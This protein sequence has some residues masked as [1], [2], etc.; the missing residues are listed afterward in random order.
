MSGS[1]STADHRA[2]DAASSM[3]AVA[4]R[5]TAR[6][7]RA[8][9]VP[10]LTERFYRVDVKRSRERGGTGLGLAIVKHIVN[11]HQGRLHDRKPAGRRQHVHRLS[12][13]R[14]RPKSCPKAPLPAPVTEVL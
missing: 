6:E 7:F 10:R 9:A 5:T 4:S 11:R 12:A 3:V 8:N 14:S 2:A 1:R 13:G